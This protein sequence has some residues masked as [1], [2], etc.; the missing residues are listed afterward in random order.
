[1][2]LVIRGCARQDPVGCNARA[3][4]TRPQPAQGRGNPGAAP[5]AYGVGGASGSERMRFNAGDRALFL[6][7][8]LH[9]L[10][11]AVLCRVL[12]L[13]RPETVLRWHRDLLARRYAH[14][15]RGQKPSGRPRP[16]SWND[17]F[18][19]PRCVT[20]SALSGRRTVRVRGMDDRYFRV[21]RRLLSAGLR[22][23]AGR[24]PRNG[25]NL[26]PR[27]RSDPTQG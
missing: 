2:Q 20:R 12:L 16:R 3:C 4:T 1:V 9:R 17:G 13:V 7:A 23:P 25:R 19:L 21:L 15:C 8:L 11:R 10:P 6:A 27:V 18:V 5:S 14:T 24:A 26:M 22:G